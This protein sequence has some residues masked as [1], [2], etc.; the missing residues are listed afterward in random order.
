MIY[1]VC[2]AHF[3]RSVIHVDILRVLQRAFKCGNI[4]IFVV[5]CGENSGIH[6]VEVGVR[7]TSMQCIVRSFGGKAAILVGGAEQTDKVGGL[8]VEESFAA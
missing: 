7:C 8:F 4:C 5:A 3:N 2:T 6:I 1:N